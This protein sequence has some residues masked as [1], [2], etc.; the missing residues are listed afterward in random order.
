MVF[1]KPAVK[2][3]RVA[4]WQTRTL[5]GRMGKRK[6]SRPFSDILFFIVQDKLELLAA[7]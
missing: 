3:V 2:K 1:A 6:G 5:E 7:K 4:E